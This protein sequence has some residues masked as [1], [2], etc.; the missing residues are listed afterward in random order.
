[1]HK[2]VYNTQDHIQ[3]CNHTQRPGDMHD[4]KVIEKFVYELMKEVISYS[5][6]CLF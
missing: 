3:E 6:M 5:S 2:T 1:M 4:R